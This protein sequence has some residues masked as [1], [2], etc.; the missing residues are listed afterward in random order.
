VAA[1]KA[2]FEVEYHH[3]PTQF[4]ARANSYGFMSMRKDLE[5]DAGRQVCWR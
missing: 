3:S 4:C 2:V 1:H 5:L